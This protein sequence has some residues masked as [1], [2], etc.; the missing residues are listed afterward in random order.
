MVMFNHI[1]LSSSIRVYQRHD[2]KTLIIHA[3][4]LR[5]GQRIALHGFDGTPYVDDLHAATEKPL[6]VFREMLRHAVQR[7]GVR[8]VDVHA[9]DWAAELLLCGGSS[10]VSGLAADRVVE[11]VDAGCACAGVCKPQLLVNRS[12]KNS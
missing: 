4:R 6:S 2:H 5:H 1:R 8:L 7:G 3:T 12:D 9:L 11:N 10:G